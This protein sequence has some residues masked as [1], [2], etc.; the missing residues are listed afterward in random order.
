MLGV[1]LD[2]ETERGLANIARRTR[3]SKSEIVREVVARYVRTHDEALIAEAKRQS[4]NAV[5]RGWSEEDAHWESVAASDDFEGAP[6]GSEP[7]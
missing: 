5:S 3:R 6:P 1:R 7:E 2:S 4:Q